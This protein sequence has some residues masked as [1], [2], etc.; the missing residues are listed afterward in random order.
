MRKLI[1][2]K[3]LLILFLF[4]NCKK[5]IEPLENKNETELK[6]VVIAKSKIPDNVDKDFKTFI[7]FFSEDSVF[8]ISRV[9][10]PMKTKEMDDDQEYEV[11]EKI[12]NKNEYTKLDF[13]YPED[14]NTRQ[15]DAYSQKIKTDN[16]KTVIEIRGIDNGIYS[17][18][19]FEKTNGK[20]ML[21][22]WTDQSN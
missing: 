2:I 11:V 12:I 19:F 14:A 17:D 22:S 4:T 13:T 15:L 6:Q 9:N 20:W 21:K 10:F 16:N 1:S 3:S 18:F 7:K 5:E 8:Q